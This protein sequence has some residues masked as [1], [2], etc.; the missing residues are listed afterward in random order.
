M[1]K[2]I[3]FI[4]I[5][6]FLS[7][8]ILFYTC[9]TLFYVE[10]GLSSSQYISFVGIA[11]F[12]KLLFEIP[13][14]II[15]DKS[16]K[17]S[18]LLISN[19]LFILSTTIFIHS[20]NYSTFL[21]AIIVNAMN[22]S[23]SS[24]IV[25]SLLYENTKDKVKFNKYLFYNSLFYNISYMI[26]MIAG[27]FVAQK[28]GLIYTYYITY[29]PFIIDSFILFM[30]KTNKSTNHKE[31]DS[32]FS[33]LKNGIHEIQQNS[34]MLNLILINS[35]MASGIKLVEES[36]P[37][38]S[39]N[40]GISVFIIGIY[41]AFMLIFC[42]IGSYIGSIIKSKNYKLLLS[43]NPILSGICILLVGLLNNYVGIF[44]ILFI[45][46]FSE[47]FNIIMTSEIHNKISSKSRVTIESI[48]QFILGIFGLCFS[49][50]MS[51]LLNHI[52]LYSMYI[53]IG[54]TV[55]LSGIVNDFLL[56]RNEKR[57]GS[58]IMNRC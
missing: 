30:I 8:F 58:K 26:A 38:Y 45:Y 3:L 54:I 11:F 16:N 23:L 56:H 35:I 43:I 1:K 42:I 50:I 18:L 25:H 52:P 29:I 49:L 17:K 32:N 22:N 27:G 2:N 34:Y 46:I 7:T 19:L 33:I 41:T 12:I 40:I 24:G 13:F 51:F 15:A 10:R 57:D 48:N 20:Y 9:D 47:S 39:S 14:G 36:H 28:F 53:L 31:V 5:H 44:F 6:T 21:L 37:E 55:I 4:N